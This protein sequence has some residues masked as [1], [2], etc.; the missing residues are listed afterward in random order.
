MKFKNIK[1]SDNKTCIVVSDSNLF[2]DNK[3]LKKKKN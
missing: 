3:V 2:Q 1:I